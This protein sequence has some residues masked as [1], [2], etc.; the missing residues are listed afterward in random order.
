MLDALLFDGRIALVCAVILIIEI[1][2]ARRIA[3]RDTV[4]FAANAVSGLGLIG[5]LYAAL[6]QLGTAAVLACLTVGLV[7]HL[8]YLIGTIRRANP[9]VGP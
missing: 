6:S 2:F 1:A 5:A 3:G 4:H 7:A 9:P 8:V